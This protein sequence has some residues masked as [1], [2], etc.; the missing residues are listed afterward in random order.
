[1][2]TTFSNHLLVKIAVPG[3]AEITHEWYFNEDRPSEFLHWVLEKEGVESLMKRR[4]AMRV[5]INNRLISF[6]DFNLK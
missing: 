2:N 3:C 4:A 6:I 5:F 1:M